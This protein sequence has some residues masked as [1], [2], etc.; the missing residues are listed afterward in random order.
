MCGV[1]KK[2]NQK[3]KSMDDATL[4]NLFAASKII[5]VVGL[6]DDP[7]RPSFG[8]AR[9]MQQ[10]GYRVV[11]VN[12]RVAQVLGEKSYATLKDIP[13]PVD[14]VNVFRKTADVL[15]IAQEAVAVGAKCL[16]QQQGVQ[17]MQADELARAHGLVSVMNRCI[18]LEY[19]RLMG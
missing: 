14:I 18:K 15:P 13:F 7:S 5:A 11:P 8:V 4:K 1:A 3:G 16:W 6:S 9:A 12:P 19:M 10:M 2:I 17:N